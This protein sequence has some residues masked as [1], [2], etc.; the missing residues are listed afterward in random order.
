MDDKLYLTAQDLLNDSF[1]LGLRIYKSGF[2]PS[3]IIGI[4]R[5]GT[6]VG[7][8][9]QEGLDYLNDNPLITDVQPPHYVEAH[10]DGGLE[11]SLGNYDSLS[12]AILAD[13]TDPEKMRE[14]TVVWTRTMVDA[15]MLVGLGTD[16]PYAGIWVGES[17]HRE[18]E[19][20]VNESGISPLRTLQAVTHDNARIMKID[21]V[22]DEEEA[23]SLVSA[24]RTGS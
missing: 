18:M 9:V 12:Q 1:K 21:E 24:R 4:W 10:N 17:L 20:W 22:Q 11:A 6:P 2:R 15:G 7:I 23:K 8:A 3:F 14:Q 19:I 5:G 16:A 13:V